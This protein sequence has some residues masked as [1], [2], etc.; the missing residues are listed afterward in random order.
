MHRTV[1]AFG[2]FDLLHAGHRS[3]LQQA[4]KLGTTLIVAVSRDANVKRLKGRRPVNDERH[5]LT[6]VISIPYVT[7]AILASADPSR[8]FT[9]IKRIR[10]SVIALGYDQTHYTDNLAAELAERGIRVRVV[11]LK[12]HRPHI[13]KS[14]ILRKTLAPLEAKRKE[15]Q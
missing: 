1:L 12:P 3:F 15:Q 8:R 6:A 5:R 10:P 7:K 14:T 9:L 2:T 13:Y 11:R 4:A